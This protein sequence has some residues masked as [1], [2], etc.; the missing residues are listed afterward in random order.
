MSFSW[1][2]YL[3]LAEGLY[4]DPTSPGPEEAALRTAISRAYYAAYQCAFEFAREE[5]FNP[6]GRAEDHN[7]VR[8]YF[9]ERKAD[10]KDS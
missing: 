10:S 1:E 9:R 3:Q 4:A 5:T 8:E 7:R 6:T 2:D